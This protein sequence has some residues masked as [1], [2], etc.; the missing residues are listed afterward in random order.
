[1]IF[2]WCEP[3]LG[4]ALGCLGALS[5]LGWEWEDFMERIYRRFFTKHGRFKEPNYVFW[6]LFMH[7]SLSLCVIPMNLYYYD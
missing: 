2:G 6:G 5:E 3:R 4:Q 1:V 7:H